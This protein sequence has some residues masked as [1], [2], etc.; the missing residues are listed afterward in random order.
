MNRSVIVWG[1]GKGCFR[2]GDCKGAQRNFWGD[3]YVYYFDFDDGLTTVSILQ[4]ALNC[5]F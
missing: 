3:A 1:C 2:E 5:T 4:N